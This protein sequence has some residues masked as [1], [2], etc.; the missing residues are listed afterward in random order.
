MEPKILVLDLNFLYEVGIQLFNTFLIVFVV[1]KFLYKP[2]MK[3]MKAREDRIRADIES[4]SKSSAEADKI[5]GEYEDKLTGIRKESD[6]ILDAAHK[7]ALENEMDI[8]KVAREESESLK[9]KTQS[10]IER[11]KAQVKDDL[12]RETIVVAT[13][14]ARKFVAESLTDE[15]K[16][17]ILD[18]TIKEMENLK[19]LA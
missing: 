5:R 11:F 4:A 9:R 7:K 8:M 2:V 12:R 15:R 10:D 16:Q 1:S 6:S 13:A 3:F 14:M 17:E 18:E 19:W